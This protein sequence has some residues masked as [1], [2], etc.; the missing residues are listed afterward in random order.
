M[1]V[2]RHRAGWKGSFRLVRSPP[3]T[4]E[5]LGL[6]QELAGSPTYH[7]GLVVIPGPSGH[8]KTTTLAALVDLR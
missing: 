1:N 8:G 2:S 3:P 4:L 7:Q 6:P 5:E